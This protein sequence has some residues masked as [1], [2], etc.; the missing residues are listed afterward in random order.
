MGA[1]KVEK[2]IVLED[3]I[4]RKMSGEL[5]KL[6]VKYYDSKEMGGQLEVRKIPLKEFLKMING[7][8]EEDMLENLELMSDMILKCCP[9]I[10]NNVKE[11]KETYGV[12][13]TMDLPN[14][15]FNDNMQELAE[16]SQLISSFY[17]LEEIDDTIKN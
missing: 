9:L 14:A 10:R 4:A 3:L 15:I 2:K 13:D 17:G 5:D 1:K 11:L 7:K 8:N 12:S 6:K 16:I